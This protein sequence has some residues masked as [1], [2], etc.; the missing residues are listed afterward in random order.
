MRQRCGCR[1]PELMANAFQK[2]GFERVR[3]GRRC[4]IP[5]YLGTAQVATD[6]DMLTQFSKVGQG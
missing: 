5:S 1:M 6:N 3:N 2:L 4:I